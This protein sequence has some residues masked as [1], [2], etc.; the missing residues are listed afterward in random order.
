MIQNKDSNLFLPFI[1]HF[2]LIELIFVNFY[3][4]NGVVWV[5][6]QN[7]AFMWVKVKNVNGALSL[8][9]VLSQHVAFLTYLN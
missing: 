2:N 1:L 4:R 6:D 3:F 8:V 9:I 5:L 7:M